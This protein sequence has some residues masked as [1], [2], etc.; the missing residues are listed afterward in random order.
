MNVYAVRHDTQTTATAIVQCSSDQLECN[1]AAESIH[2]EAAS[3]GSVVYLPS[4]P[5]RCLW[6]MH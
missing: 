6:R 2:F 1:T 5:F 4:I 3:I